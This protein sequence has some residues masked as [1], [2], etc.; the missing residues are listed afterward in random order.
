MQVSNEASSRYFEIKYKVDRGEA[1]WKALT[2][3]EQT[4]MDEVVKLW[5]KAGL[6][7][8][9]SSQNSIGFLY[10]QGRGLPRDCDQAAIWFTMAGDRGQVKAQYNLVWTS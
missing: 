8:H 1:D 4:E 3:E 5:L 7:G 9:S 6:E 2:R 10:D